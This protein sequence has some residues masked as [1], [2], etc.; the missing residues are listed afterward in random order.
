ME[1]RKFVLSL[2]AIVAMAGSAQE[3][4]QVFIYSPNEKA[5]LHIAQYTDNIWQEIGQLCT[6]DY[7]VMTTPQC[8]KPVVFANDNGTFD[9]YYQTKGGDK[10]WVSASSDF[11][12]FNKDEKSQID[13]EAWTRDTATTYSLPM[14][15]CGASAD[16]KRVPCATDTT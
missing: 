5:G 3:T 4:K 7:P 6:S 9:I 10:R 2:L 1:F 16:R 15:P 13:Q 14:H 8:L 12:Q 11:R